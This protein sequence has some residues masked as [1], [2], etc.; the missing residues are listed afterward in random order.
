MPDILDLIDP[1]ELT[2]FAR[3]E[4]ANFDDQVQSYSRFMPYQGVNDIRYAYNKQA[5]AFVDEAVFRAY[6]AESP[7]GRRPDSSRIVGEI[8]AISRKIPLSEYAQLRARQAPDR[9]IID[10]IFDD[11]RNLARGIAARVE[12]A[13]A[14][15]LETGAININENGY[16][17]TYTSGRHASLTPADL[18]GTAVWSDYVNAT[19]ISDVIAW[20]DLIRARVGMSPTELRVSSTVMAHIQQCDE[21]RAFNTA[22]PLAPQRLSRD[23]VNDAFVGLAGVRVVV[24]ETPAGMTNPRD[25]TKVILM[26]DTVPV[27]RTLYGTP[28]EASEPDYAGISAQP[29]IYAGTW[30]E[31]DPV[32][33]W[34]KAVAITLPVLT[35]PDAT[36]CCKVIA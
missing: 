12:R 32:T 24:D 25:A 34:T 35:I 9:D 27:G 3:L 36:L 7:T 21:V 30:K 4:A 26:V 19:P 5:A 29:G 14:I 28:V 8:P 20:A 1:V 33:P 16:Q 2:E 11:A 6:D 13:R 22:A 23:R 18:A 17:S 10:S 15:V 31:K